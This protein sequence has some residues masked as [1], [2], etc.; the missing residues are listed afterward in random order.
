MEDLT[1][2]P[3][4]S[5]NTS[6]KP[7]LYSSDDYIQ[8][9]C[10]LARPTFPGIPESSHRVQDRRILQTLEAMSWSPSQKEMSMYKLTNFISNVMPLG[11]ATSVP[12]DAEAD[13]WS[14]EDPLAQ[15]YRRTGNLCSSKA[16]WTQYT[17]QILSKE[18]QFAQLDKLNRLVV[19]G[20]GHDVH[21][22]DIIKE[23]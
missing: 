14:R 13:F 7:D 1:S 16:F 2:N 10:H 5:A 6:T 11:K 17:I 4:H 3:K 21:Y 22:R 15:I 20:N 23:T 18:K 12:D 8:S 19:T 9:I